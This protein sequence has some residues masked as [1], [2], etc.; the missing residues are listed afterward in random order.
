MMNL[1][2]KN[3]HTE[4]ILTSQ[5]MFLGLS[6]NQSTRNLEVGDYF[7]MFDNKKDLLIFIQKEWQK[8]W[9]LDVSDD[10]IVGEIEYNIL[11]DKNE[12][13]STT[14]TFK[15]LYK[16]ELKNLKKQLKFS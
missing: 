15:K 16:N 14:P 7:C 9:F 3:H 11:T 12:F 13:I 6:K 8:V 10:Q 2:T 4:K 5:G 1:F